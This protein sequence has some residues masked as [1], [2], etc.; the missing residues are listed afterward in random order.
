MFSEIFS[1]PYYTETVSHGVPRWKHNIAWAKER[2]KNRG[3]I[4]PPKESGRGWWELTL[5]GENYYIDH[6]AHRDPLNY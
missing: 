5:K 4:K 3:L 6:L 1:Q 2:A